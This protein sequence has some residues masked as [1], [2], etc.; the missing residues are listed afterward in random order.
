[1]VQA[2]RMI[3]AS[4]E[5]GELD[6]QGFLGKMFFV[7]VEST[8]LGGHSHLEDQGQDGVE[9][10]LHHR[11]GDGV[12]GSHSGFEDLESLEDV[13]E[14]KNDLLE[15]HEQLG[16]GEGGGHVERILHHMVDQV[17]GSKI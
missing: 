9:Q 13:E 7:V 16:C 8:E 10:L 4:L 14:V 5:S 15:Y 1:M 12:G 11:P 2:E 6:N 17:L 3:W